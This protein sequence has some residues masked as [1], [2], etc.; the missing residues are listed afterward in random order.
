MKF[1]PHDVGAE[2]YL[3]Q[4][5]SEQ[6]DQW[7]VPSSCKWYAE[8]AIQELEHVSNNGLP[9]CYKTFFDYLCDFWPDLPW[10]REGLKAT[11]RLLLDHARLPTIREKILAEWDRD[12]RIILGEPLN[13][14]CS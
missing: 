6:A 3:S 2:Q 4:K 5:R 7:A 10:D 9:D 11:C 12:V 8:Y 1:Y 13:E 14:V